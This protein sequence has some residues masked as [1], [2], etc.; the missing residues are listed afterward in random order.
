M[1]PPMCGVHPTYE[2]S[3][4]D[5]LSRSYYSR[6]VTV[7]ADAYEQVWMES[8]DTEITERQARLIRS[9]LRR[10]HESVAN[11]CKM[12]KMPEKIPFYMVKV[13]AA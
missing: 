8:S 6:S 5:W 9:V 3:M 13:G 12:N 10:A 11:I 4:M 2:E 1:L 7:V